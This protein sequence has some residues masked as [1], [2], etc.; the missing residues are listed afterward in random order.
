[1]ENTTPLMVAAGLGYGLRGPSAG[2]GGRRIDIQENVIAVLTQLLEWGS[3]VNALND[4]GQSAIHGAAA[5][6]APNV[7]CSVR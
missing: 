3:D 1:M 4:H 6:A 5:S 7:A 2:L